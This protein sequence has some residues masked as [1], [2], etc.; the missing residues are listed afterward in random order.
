MDDFKPNSHRFKEEQAKQNEQ[1]NS[2]TTKQLD[3]P[4]INQVKVKKKS[5]IAKVAN[6]FIAEDIKTVGVTIWTD[7]IVPTVKKIITDVVTEGIHHLIYGDSARPY[8]T[9]TASKVSYGSYYKSN[10]T[11]TTTTARP[12]VNNS[13]SYDDILFPTRGDA[14]LVL[15]ALRKALMTYNIVS[16]AD[17]YDIAQVTTDNPQLYK[18]GWISL[19]TATIVRT[20]DGDYIIKLPK[21]QPIE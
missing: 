16:V 17:F 14:E 21:A 2:A 13:F 11:T 6:N 5:E 18:Y 7:V 8:N 4:K 15:D 3:T 12:A 10:A 19:N 1:K 9:T 20:M